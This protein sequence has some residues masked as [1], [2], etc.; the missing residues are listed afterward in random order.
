MKDS[1]LFLWNFPRSAR[2]AC[3]SETMADNH[4][5]EKMENKKKP[6]YMHFIMDG[7]VSTG[8]QS[9]PTLSTEMQIWKL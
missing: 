2:L 6:R 7:R 4:S 3:T 5:L 9:Y 1:K 8:H